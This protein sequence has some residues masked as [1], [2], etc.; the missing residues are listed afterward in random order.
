MKIIS[1][2]VVPIFGND[3]HWLRIHDA[4]FEKSE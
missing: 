3:E 4:E 2:N 1:I